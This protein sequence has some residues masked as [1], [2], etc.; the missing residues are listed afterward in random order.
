VR[1]ERERSADPDHE[2]HEAQRVEPPP[3][4]AAPDLAEEQS[5]DCWKS[6]RKFTAS[7][8]A[9]N[10]T[11]TAKP[12]DTNHHEAA[13]APADSARFRRSMGWIVKAWVLAREVA[14]GVQPHEAQHE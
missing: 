2:Q 10:P 5:C 9:P 14:A 6:P 8:S 7:S 11:E 1:A 4:A 3:A 13:V 12:G